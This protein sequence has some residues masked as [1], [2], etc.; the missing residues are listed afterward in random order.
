MQADG[1]CVRVPEF[2]WILGGT[3]SL[4]G[5]RIIRMDPWGGLFP[6][7]NLDGHQGCIIIENAVFLVSQVGK[8][9]RDKKNRTPEQ[10]QLEEQR[11]K[12]KRHE[13]KRLAIL[14]GFATTCR[15]YCGFKV[16]GAFEIHVLACFLFFKL[17]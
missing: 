11:R 1:E 13:L 12:A 5:I 6:D 15:S 8:Q 4:T 10:R 7:R 17:S 2:A 16:R 9:K 3:S 14:A